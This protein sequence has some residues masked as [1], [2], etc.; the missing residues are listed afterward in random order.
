MPTYIHNR[1]DCFAWIRSHI[2]DFKRDR[3]ALEKELDEADK[4]AATIEREADEE[5][6]RLEKRIKELSR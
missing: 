6:A 4:R 1:D 5:V 3:D 2:E